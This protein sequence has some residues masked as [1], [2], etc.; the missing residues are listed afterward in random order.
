M[1][2]DV[3]HKIVHQSSDTIVRWWMKVVDCH[4]ARTILAR[5]HVKTSNSVEI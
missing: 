5:V 1:Q 3:V 4:F 2:V